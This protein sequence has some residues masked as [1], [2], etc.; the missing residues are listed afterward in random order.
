MLGGALAGI[1]VVEIASDHAASAGKL[2]A[3]LGAEVVLVEPPGGHPGRRYPPFAEDVPGDDRSLWWW[4]YQCGKRSIVLD[5]EDAGGRDGFRE[6][7]RHSDLVLEGEPPGRLGGLGID[8][9]RC[10]AADGRLVWV[11]VTGYG[12]ETA[13]RDEQFTDLTLQAGGGQMWMTGYDDHRLPP[14][15]WG[16]DQGF[17]IG[18]VWAVI[19]ALVALHGRVRDGAG[20]LVDVSMH[21]AANVTT[22]Q[23]NHHWLVAR[24]EVGRLTCRHAAP[25]GRPTQETMAVSA[26]GIWVNTGVPG[27]LP[28]DY[29]QLLGWLA[30]LGLAD[31]FAESVWLDIGARREATD[32]GAVGLDP[33][34]TE[35]L[36]AAR[37][38]MTLIATTLSAREFFEGA[39]RRGIACGPLYSPDEAMDSVHSRARGFPVRLYYEEVDR[40]VEHPGAP[41]VLHGA[42]W[43]APRRAPKLGEYQH[44]APSARLDP[45]PPRI[46]LAHR[47][48]EH[49]RHEEQKCP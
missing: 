13:R 39:Q 38:A 44:L 17:H 32:Y 6:L 22:E 29:A 16:G 11:S 47:T 19:G 27:R 24:Q 1:R 8:A 14:V 12:R 26:D 25:V 23:G 43:S 20:T 5:L 15:R 7:V 36:S 33:E 45:A 34:V 4:H 49:V 30:E 41:F 31:G 2:L 37:S 48:S 9:D 35:C 28:R 46:G 42:P 18:G 40:E 3:E 21:A 10:R